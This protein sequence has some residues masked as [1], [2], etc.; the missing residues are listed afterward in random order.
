MVEERVGVTKEYSSR[1]TYMQM[2]ANLMK[3][4]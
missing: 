1:Q 4:G 3:N 2:H